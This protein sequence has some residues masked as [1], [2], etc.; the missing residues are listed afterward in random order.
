MSLTDEY[1]STCPDV[2]HTD[3]SLVDEEEVYN[4]LHSKEQTTCCI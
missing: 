3:Q 2:F 1:F 4:L